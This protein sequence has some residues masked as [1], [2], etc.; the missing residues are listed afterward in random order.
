MHI[1][2]KYLSII[3]RIL[4]HDCEFIS[5]HIEQ[6]LGITSEEYIF[7]AGERVVVTKKMKSDKSDENDITAA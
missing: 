2:S 4:R 5:E 6:D 7:S 1:L 3:C